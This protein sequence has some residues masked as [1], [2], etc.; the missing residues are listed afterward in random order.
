MNQA[1][2][3]R[4]LFQVIY[5]ALLIAVV[6]ECLLIPTRGGWPWSYKDSIA[7]GLFLFATILFIVFRRQAYAQRKPW[8]LIFFWFAAATSLVLFRRWGIVATGCIG[9]L[10]LLTLVMRS[11]FLTEGISREAVFK[12]LLLLA[13]SL[14]ALALTE[15]MLR[16]FSGRLPVEVQ[17][18]IRADPSNYGV[19]HPYIGNLHRPNNALVLSGKGLLCGPPYGWLWFS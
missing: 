16:L 3:K 5:P 7:G 17:Q 11:K 9:L 1:F 15:G 14:F 19:V 6:V 18:M 8:L 4:I 10:L 2:Q 12:I 13:A